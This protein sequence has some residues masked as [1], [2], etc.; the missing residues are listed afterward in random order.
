MLL[1]VVCRFCFVECESAAMADLAVKLCVNYPLGKNNN[2]TAYSFAYYNDIV[3]TPDE[4][5]PAQ[6]IFTPKV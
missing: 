4:W 1:M 6:E 2:F 5:T 3:N